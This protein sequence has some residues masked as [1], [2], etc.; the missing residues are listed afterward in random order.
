MGLSIG[1]EL[2]HVE[3]GDVIEIVEAKKVRLR[4]EV[5]SLTRAQQIISGAPYAV[6]PG[7]YWKASDG[8]TISEH[9]EATYPHD[10]EAEV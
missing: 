1:S 6:Q 8:R 3:T 2:I 4:D 10:D 9:Y 5:V 7:R